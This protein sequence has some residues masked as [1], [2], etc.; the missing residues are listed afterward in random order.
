VVFSCSVEE[1]TDVLCHQIAPPAAA[2]R[3]GEWG[4]LFSLQVEKPGKRPPDRL[5]QDPLPNPLRIPAGQGTHV[6]RDTRN[7]VEITHDAHDGAP[8]ISCELPSNIPKMMRIRP[9]RN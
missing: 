7:F 2:N 4:R 3:E 5:V 1:G 9:C 6:I 8:D